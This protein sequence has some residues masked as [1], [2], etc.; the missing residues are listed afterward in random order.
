[1]AEE[2]LDRPDISRSH[3]H[4]AGECVTERVQARVLNPELFQQSSEPDLQRVD[5]KLLPVLI[6]EY[7]SRNSRPVKRF[8]PIAPFLLPR[9]A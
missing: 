7:P 1:V 2:L 4:V 9:P 5:V 3:H 6:G 8:L